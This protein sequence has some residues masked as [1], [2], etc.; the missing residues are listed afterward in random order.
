M[1]H[2]DHPSVIVFLTDQQRWDTTGLGG[3]PEGLT[4]NLDHAGRFGCWFDN[5][6][7]PQ[8]LCT[9]ARSSLQTGR[10]ATENG[11]HRNGLV[12]DEDADTLA[13]RFGAAGYTTAYIG[14]WHLADLSSRGPVRPEQRGG[15]QHWLAA[16]AVEHTSDAYRARLWDA[17]QEPVE[18]PGYRVDALTDAAIRFIDAQGDRPYLLFLSFL[19]PHHQNHRDDY[20][21][22]AVYRDRYHGH[23]LPPDLASLGG[24]SHQQIGGYYGMIKRLDEAYGRIL[25][26]LRSRGNERVPRGEAGPADAG[27]L[28]EVI[29]V[30]S[31]DHGCHFKTR[32]AEYKRSVHDASTRVPLLIT[33]PG[34]PR[35]RVVDDVVST[36]GLPATLC[37]LAGIDPMEGAQPSLRPVM[38]ST[39][40]PGG[41]AFV[42]VSESEVARAVR[43]R[44]WKYGVTAPQADP[45]ADAGADRWVET[46][47]YDLEADPSELTNLVAHASHRE[48]R[49][50]LRGRL[51]DWMSRVGEPPGSIQPAPAELP[52][53]QRVVSPAEVLG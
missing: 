39:E 37:D 30:F 16:N 31:S 25:D 46:Y 43:T 36:V 33:G 34:V 20:P 26:A 47:L 19:E 29:T 41:E 45:H 32:N 52:A 6:H 17:D 14:K 27:A 38:T 3:N 23:W 7:T 11:V 49:A 2:P 9:P 1:P 53:G 12:L 51:E 44:R 13:K 8:P 42:Q 50:H 40:P 35:G 24:T 28:D 15:Y 4:P 22:P 18:L 21:A 48:V 10:F 5:A